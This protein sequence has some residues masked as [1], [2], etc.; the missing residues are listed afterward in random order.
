MRWVPDLPE[1]DLIHVLRVVI[2]AEVPE[3]PAPGELPWQGND[4]DLAKS[5]DEGGEED[6]M[7]VDNGTTKSVPTLS[8][9]LCRLARYPTS[10]VPLRHALRSHLDLATLGPV[11]DVLDLWLT[12][13]AGGRKGWRGAEPP[14]SSVLRLGQA[15]LDTF[16]V[17]LLTDTG[18]HD[19]LERLE[20]GIRALV[21][22]S[23]DLQTLRGPLQAFVRAQRAQRLYGP[24]V[25]AETEEEASKS[26]ARAF[27][28]SGR[29]AHERRRNA[30]EAAIA[31]SMA[32]GEYVV[33]DFDL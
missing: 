3:P 32:V 1:S 19:R 31:E 14:L 20:A 18:L 7:L 30:R 6:A 13:W 2:D 23:T 16:F 4:D 10:L 17:G 21:V 24:A 33:E 25:A 11:L 12:W 9:Y 15:I 22:V 29:D 28:R 8:K 5:E 26:Q 27:E